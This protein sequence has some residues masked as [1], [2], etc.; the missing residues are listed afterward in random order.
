MSG[1]CHSEP[2]LLRRAT[3]E[4]RA[5]L[6]LGA[7]TLGWLEEKAP[8]FLHAQEIQELNGFNVEQ[9][10]FTFLL[11]RYCAK[12]ALAECLGRSGMTEWRLAA[13]VFGQPLVRGPGSAA[14]RV[15]IAHSGKWGGAIVFPDE[16]PM[17]IDLEE[18]P[19]RHNDAIKTQLEP[20][21]IQF[22]LAA[23]PPG[24]DALGMLWTAK[25]ALSKV[26]GTGLTT[27]FRVFQVSQ[28]VREGAWFRL[29]FLHFAQYKALCFRF[30]ETW[31]S[32][33][34]PRKTGVS[35]EPEALLE[36]KK[37]AVCSA[38]SSPV[39]HWHDLV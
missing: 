19:A 3:G 14:L 18:T 25:E 11:G 39:Q 2:L 38:P 9:R 34:L 16:H 33:V 24:I 17:A 7:W 29:E 32:M 30:G 20:A 8:H 37:G 35:L 15:S 6:V 21:E 5:H 27:P 36:K 31:F 13:S 12:L 10:R 4:F 26:L 1:H 22:A 23:H 28:I